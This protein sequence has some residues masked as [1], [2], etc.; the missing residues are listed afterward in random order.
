MVKS[1]PTMVRKLVPNARYELLKAWSSAVDDW[2]HS[3][4][5]VYP[6]ALAPT[7]VRSVA[8]MTLEPELYTALE[9]E[10]ALGTG[11]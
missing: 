3:H 4:M 6:D 10:G 2:V 7:A 9:E 1:A 11:R 8:R 5:Q